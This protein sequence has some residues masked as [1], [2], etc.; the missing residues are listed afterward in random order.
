ML[1]F[2]RCKKDIR[3]ENTRK[4]KHEERNSDGEKEK[5]EKF[6]NQKQLEVWR[7]PVDTTGLFEYKG[8]TRC[9]LLLSLLFSDSCVKRD[10]SRKKKD[11]SRNYKSCACI[12]RLV[13][14]EVRE[15]WS[16]TFKQ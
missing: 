14:Q 15:D 1:C 2:F 11:S 4:R 6:I 8:I 7:R 9:C 10:L 13:S 12:E 16:P 5:W 3:L